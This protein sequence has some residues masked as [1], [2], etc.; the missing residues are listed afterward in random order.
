MG[1]GCAL[2]RHQVERHRFEIDRVRSGSCVP[3]E[4]DGVPKEIERRGWQLRDFPSE[5]SNRHKEIGSLSRASG[6]QDGM[7]RTAPIEGSTAE[8]RVGGLVPAPTRGHRA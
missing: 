5:C 2:E 4:L 1:A 6:D 7:H 3:V 8:R